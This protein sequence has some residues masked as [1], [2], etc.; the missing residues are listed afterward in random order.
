MKKL[1]WHYKRLIFRLKKKIDLDKDLFSSNNLNELF[2][3][4]GSDKGTMV[5]HPY[6]SRGE[7]IVGH[8]FGDYYEK[9]FD[10]LRNENFNLLEIGTWKGA[11]IAA[12]K[13]YF[14]NANIYGLDK[15]FKFQYRSN[16]ISFYNCDTTKKSDLQIIKKKFENKKFQI[17]VD[18]G[19]HFLNDIISNLKFFFKFLDKKGI[20]VIE[21]FRHPEYYKFLDDSKNKE[22]NVTEII[23]KWKKREFFKSELLTKVD[24]LTLMKN[25]KIISSYKG[26]KKDKDI[27]VSDIAFIEKN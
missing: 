27:N 1:S 8:G 25:I 23:K 22:L 11:S 14:L 16:K 26:I 13:K 2:N 21:D 3:H 10:R 5:N 19:S 7:K 4:Y 9:Y 24:Q 18:D 17:I 15:N 6:G 12:F 20:Y